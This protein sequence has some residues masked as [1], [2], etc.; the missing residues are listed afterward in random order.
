MSHYPVV[1]TA[2]FIKVLVSRSAVFIK[3]RMFPYNEVIIMN[4]KDRLIHK[5]AIDADKRAAEFSLK[6]ARAPSEEKETYLAAMQ[7]EQW[8]AD[9]CRFCLE[10]L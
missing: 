7:F 8:F 10:D 2:E 9:T 4:T 3:S 1:K 6:F 5:L